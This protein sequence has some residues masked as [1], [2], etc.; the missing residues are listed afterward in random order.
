MSYEELRD[1]LDRLLR[2]TAMGEAVNIDWGVISSQR[3]RAVNHD[4]LAGLQV[5][6]AVATSA[7][8]AA[9]KNPYGEVEDRYLRLIANT[10][11]RHKKSVDGY[12]IK[13]WCNDRE[14][15]K[16]LADL[17]SL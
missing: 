12:G 4:Q 6:D 2:N 5:A 17:A 8:Y 3:V 11:Y 13:T 14:E 7:Y 1:Y 15:R 9:N 16:R 10:V